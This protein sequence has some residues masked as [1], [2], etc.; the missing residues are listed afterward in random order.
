MKLTSYKEY[1]LEKVIYDM[2]LESNLVFSNNFLGLLSKMG[3]NEIAKELI[4]L[5]S[6]DIDGVQHNYIDTTDERDSVSFTPDRKA[7]E[8]NKDYVE[9]WKVIADTRYL[10]HSDKNDRIFERLG[11]VKADREEWHP[12]VGTIGNI[13]KETIG[14]QGKIYVLFESNGKTSVLN[15]LALESQN[16]NSIVWSTSRNS[17]KVG[18]LVRSILKA[19][20]V[21]F[22]EKDI[23]TFVNKY[24][25]TFDFSKNMIRQ[26][27]IVKGDD[28]KYW[29]KGNNY[30]GSGGTLNS[31][32]MKNSNSSV[33]D[34]YSKNSSISLVILYDDNGTIDDDVKYTSDKIKGRA[35][36][37]ETDKGMFMDRIYTAYD[38]DV[39]LFIEFAIK[40]NFWFKTEQDMEPDTSITNGRET[41]ELEF[42]VRLD[43]IN[44]DGYPYCDTICYLN[45][46]SETISNSNDNYDLELK[47]TDGSAVRFEDME[48]DD[49]YDD[50]DTW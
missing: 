10:T 9:E 16:N 43:T 27:D 4:K 25:A 48:D 49:G 2:I 26:F 34:L 29:Y 50:D 47:N 15:K 22:I 18:R 20:G 3:S 36:L 38:S 30:V 44:L 6:V 42:T 7:T 37:W 46:T 39:N 41:K 40:S 35:I 13:M 23:E 19:G 21:S 28:I 45:E 31:S 14:S 17:I 12:S 8:I 24:K 11:Y 32:C 33:F 1:I 5:Y